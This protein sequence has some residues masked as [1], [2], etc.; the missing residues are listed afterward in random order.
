MSQT[1]EPYQVRRE[2]NAPI[3]FDGKILFEEDTYYFNG[4]N[5]ARWFE[6]K[7][8]ETKTGKFVAEWIYHTNWQGESDRFFCEIVDTDKAAREELKSFSPQ[9]LEKIGFPDRPQYTDRQAN[10][11]RHLKRMWDHI[12]SEALE[13]MPERI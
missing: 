5:Q 8:Y 6:A 7:I 4:S 11:F 2:G 10:L 12:I 9:D 13:D 1:Y 3:S